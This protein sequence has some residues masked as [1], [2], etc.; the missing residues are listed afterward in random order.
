MGKPVKCS[1]RKL[2]ETSM[3]QGVKMLKKL[4]R[5]KGKEEGD[6]LQLVSLLDQEKSQKMLLGQEWQ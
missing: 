6:Y 5:C 4:L 3:L 2:L 1:K